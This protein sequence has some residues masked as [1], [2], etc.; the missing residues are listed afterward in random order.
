MR[1]AEP[2]STAV[3]EGIRIRV[4]SQYLAEQSSPRDDRYVFAYTIMIA[5]EGIKTAQLRTRH[6]II[7]DGRGTVEEVRGDGVVGEQ[8]R[9]SPGQSFQYT[10]GCVLTTSVGTMQGSYR[11]WRD[12]GS[13]FDAAIAPFSLASPDSVRLGSDE[14]N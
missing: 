11:M 5:N 2:T 6:W 4:Q 7:T 8:P 13:Y 12:D 3:T 1:A 14:A 10:S 9:L